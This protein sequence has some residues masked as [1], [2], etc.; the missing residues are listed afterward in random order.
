MAYPEIDTQEEL[1]KCEKYYQT[2]Y[3]ADK[4]PGNVTMKN[5][6]APDS[7]AIQFMVPANGRYTH[8]F[9][10][11]TRI[12]PTSLQIWS[13]SGSTANAFNVTAQ[14]DLT[15]A[16]GGQGLLGDRRASA[17]AATALISADTPLGA[18]IH[19][20]AGFAALDIIA[21]HYHADSEL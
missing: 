4:Y 21:F 20:V 7:S 12:T 14:K 13:P 11:P 16:A 15:K 1:R 8:N 10:V 17:S 3:P 5:P 2:S 6:K 19:I 9:S 18:D